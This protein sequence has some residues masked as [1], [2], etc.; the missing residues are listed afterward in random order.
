MEAE[1]QMLDI[2]CWIVFAER[3]N[4]IVYLRVLNEYFLYLKHDCK[5]CFNFALVA[6]LFFR[7][8]TLTKFC[9][10]PMT[11]TVAECIPTPLPS[12][13]SLLLCTDN[14]AMWYCIF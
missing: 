9:W 3:D 7:E 14:S 11:E 2:L 5:F 8:R 10:S 6:Y 4:N 12:P 1:W 13:P